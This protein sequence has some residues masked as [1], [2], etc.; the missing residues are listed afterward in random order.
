[1]FKRE[2]Q[3]GPAAWATRLGVVACCVVAVFA[4]RAPAAADAHV[5][6]QGWK[7]S[8]DADGVA[9]YTRAMPG[10]AYAQVRVIASVCA[11]LPELVAFVEDVAHF[12]TWIPDTQDA[13]LLE[14]PSPSSQIYYLRTSMPWPIKHRDMIYRLTEVADAS[15]PGSLSVVMEGLPNH[16]PVYAGVVRMHSAAGRWDFHE[17]AGRT[18]ISLDLHIEPGGRIPAWLGTQRL[19]GTP[20]AMLRNLS[21]RFATACHED[22][23]TAKPPMN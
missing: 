7:H 13:R 17:S 18:Q 4:S 3:G 10:S 15:A 8:S 5:D 22:A 9:L 6:A 14:R 21:R 23:G 20:R 12:D 2:A 1:M 11:T 19:V 16:L